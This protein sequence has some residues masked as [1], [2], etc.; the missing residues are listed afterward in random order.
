MAVEGASD[1]GRTVKFVLTLPPPRAGSQPPAGI[2]RVRPGQPSCKD[3]ARGACRFGAKC[4][5]SHDVSHGGAARPASGGGAGSSGS[6]QAFQHG[7]QMEAWL[8]RLQG[9]SSSDILRAMS[10]DRMDSLQDILNRQSLPVSVEA[11]LITLFANEDIRTSMLRTEVN[12]IYGALMGSPFLT[13]L[14]SHLVNPPLKT[15]QKIC[16]ICEELQNRTADGWK[17]VPLDA[18]NARAQNLPEGVAKQQLLADVERMLF[19]REQLSRSAEEKLHRRGDNATPLIVSDIQSLH[20]TFL[21]R[22][23][24][25]TRHWESGIRYGR[26]SVIKSLSNQDCV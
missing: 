1:T 25:C 8:S 7:G 6:R 5:Y 19:Y 12:T 23:S 26:Y 17:A 22:E 2:G 16:V 13:R 4:R 9:Q 18:V 24:C 15:L 3:F 10:G 21:E 14:Q 11:K 20:R